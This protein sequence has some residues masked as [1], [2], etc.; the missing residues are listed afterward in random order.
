M[1]DLTEEQKKSYRRYNITLPTVLSVIWLVLTH[2]LSAL[3]DGRLNR[4]SF[5]G[6]PL[7][8]DEAGNGPFAIFVVESL[9]PL[10]S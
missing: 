6:V 9:R 10:T 8:Y 7:I 2:L 3:R 1:A 4:S 5:L